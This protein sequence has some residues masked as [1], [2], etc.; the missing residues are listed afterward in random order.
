MLQR[1]CLARL[2][3]LAALVLFPGCSGGEKLPTVPVIGTVTYN[4]AP[5]AGADISFLPKSAE[6]GARGAS[7]TTDANGQFKM[8][9]FLG[10]TT[11]V[12]GALPGEY[13]VSIAKRENLTSAL[14]AT[15]SGGGAPDTGKLAE[16]AD[17][18]SVPPPNSRGGPA[19][20]TGPPPGNPTG[21]EGK[22]L[23][24]EKYESPET[25]GFTATVKS[26]GNE[27]FKFEMVD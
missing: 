21:M 13:Q 26:S 25:S 16:E 2:F 11:T 10:G 8:Q 19:G 9:T 15:M 20:G 7:G 4:G 24:P 17:T 27:P 1:I 23:I 14:A 12:A 22:S 6:A 5:L 3:G 18:Q